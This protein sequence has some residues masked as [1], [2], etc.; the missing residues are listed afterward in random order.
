MSKKYSKLYR[1]LTQTK[2]AYEE[3]KNINVPYENQ[4]SRILK[5]L[6]KLL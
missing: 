6:K 5:K 3:A 4:D 1:V 2:K